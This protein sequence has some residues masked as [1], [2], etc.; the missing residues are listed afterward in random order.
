MRRLRFTYVLLAGVLMFAGC[1][2]GDSDTG[3]SGTITGGAGKTVY[4]ERFVNNH[5]VKSDS[6]VIGSDGAFRIVPARPL[7]KN[8]YRLMFDE[9]DYIIL[10]TDSTEKI[11]I[12]A[13]AGKLGE[14]A[15][16]EGSEDTR[17]LR[18]FEKEYNNRLSKQE[19]PSARLR[20]PGLS[21]EEVSKYREEVISARKE[22]SAFVRHWL[23]SNSSTPAAIGAVQ[24]LDIRTDLPQYQKVMKDQ[25]PEFTATTFYKMLRQKVEFAQSGGMVQDEQEI[26]DP[27]AMPQ[28]RVE[29]VLIGL[30]KTVP[31]IALPDPDGTVRRL[32]DLRGKVVLLDFWASWCGP[33]R[34]ENPAVV[35]A[36][37]AYNADGFEVFSVS[38]D[39]EKPRW[40]DA[41]AEDGLV[42]K[43]HVSD[44]NGWSSKPAADYGVHSI[45]FPVL[46]DREGKVIAYGPNARGPMLQAHLKQMFGR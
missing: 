17:V 27:R 39:K 7:E 28:Q 31:E 14:S 6:S 3:I 11:R 33:C 10:I 2:Q 43:N 18:D 38:L 34:R 22:V 1:G 32:S 35:E 36:Y 15:K 41:I 45:P 16:V 23:E 12:T 9:R 42:W 5:G 13:E 4:L 40:V 24:V 37:N 29:G 21:D 20:E 46:L 19:E 44:L 25:R 8:Y 26:S 30:G